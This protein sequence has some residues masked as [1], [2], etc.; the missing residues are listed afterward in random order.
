MR[1]IKCICLI[2]LTFITSQTLAVEAQTT[3]DFIS[4]EKFTDFKSQVNSPT[5]DLN[6]LMNEL[7]ELIIASSNKILPNDKKLQIL[8]NI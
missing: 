4:P 3:V 2:L 7:Q 6:K 5:K 8:I 1:L